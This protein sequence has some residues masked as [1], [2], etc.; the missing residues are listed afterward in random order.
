M[1]LMIADDEKWVR[2]TIK[3]LIP[4]DKL[5]MTLV[6]EASNGIEALELCR[7]HRPDILL[8]DIMM[9]GLTG[10]DLIKELRS[11][12]PDIRIAIISGYSDFDYARAAMKY[13]I[14]DYLLKPVDE[15]ELLQVIER[16]KKEI[17]R[18]AVQNREKEQE[19]EQYKLALP[20]MLE[21]F[22]NQTIAS[23]TMTA[24]QIRCEL[25]K[26]GISFTRHY[27]S[28]AIFS[29]DDKDSLE[30]RNKA[31]YFRRIVKRVMKRYLGAVTFPLAGGSPETASVINHDTAGSEAVSQAFRLCSLIFVR[32]LG[33]SVSAGLSSP[34]RQ[35]GMLQQLGRQ[36]SKALEK[37]FWIGPGKLHRFTPSGF[38]EEFPL[39]LTEEALNKITLNMKL[40]N[41]QT[42]LSYVDGICAELNRYGDIEPALVREFFWQLVQSMINLLNIQLPFI[43][44]ETL[45][46]GEQPYERIKRT[47][48]MDQLADVTRDIMQRIFDF[49]HDK[50]PINN[51]NLVENAKKVIESNYAGDIS[52]EQVARH[53]HLSPAYLSELFKKETG[54]SFIDYKTIVR[55]ENAKRL[56]S[57]MPMNIYDIS[58]R[59]GYS[60][61]KYFSKLF[62][63]ITGKTVFEYKKEMK[64]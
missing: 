30:D 56:I 23:N 53:V 44:H 27:F 10:L 14:T 7:Q 26:Y 6:C 12:S 19:K 17:G 28:V 31:E 57:S 9:P 59:V 54:M 18:E 25:S 33:I 51:T 45:V 29:P 43:R 13:G 4:F 52:L 5:D 11:C 20:V 46:T 24:D 37:R 47:L 22:L 61:P 49:F 3:A 41:I 2:T 1:K 34:V 55:I 32:R 58:A 60:D 42:A 50:N 39:Q 64:R 35:L 15:V 38:S 40:S 62:K 16:F 63:K 36:S 8:T 21:A 48:F